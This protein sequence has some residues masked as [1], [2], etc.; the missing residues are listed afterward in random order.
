MT[1]SLDKVDRAL[2]SAL[3][4][5]AGL[6]QQ[7]LAELVGAS[8]ASCWRRIKSLEDLGLLKKPIRKV[9]ASKLGLTVSVFCNIRVKSHDEATRAAFEA[10]VLESPEI[11]SCFLTS[12]DWDFL[13]RLVACDVATYERFLMR[14]ILGHPSVAA[15]SSH[16]A[17]SIVK[18]ETCL[19]IPNE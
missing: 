12:G 6:S 17:L 3:Q 5:D 9:D 8:P 4:R 14:K 19:P 11:L 16:F 1:I 15:A 13:L 18:D 2:L 10:F 7:V